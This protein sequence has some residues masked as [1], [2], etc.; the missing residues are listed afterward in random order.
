MLDDQYELLH[1]LGKGGS[2]Q[3][4]SAVDSEGN[5][6][7]IKVIRND[8]DY[9]QAKAEH[10]IL[11]EN[12]VMEKLGCHNNILKSIACSTDGDI[13]YN[14]QSAKVMYHVLEYCANGTLKDYVKHTG[15]FDENIAKFSFIQ[16]VSAVQHLHQNMFVHMDLKLENILLDDYFNIRLA[17]LGTTY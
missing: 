13:N 7:A 3:V 17:D 14:G 8:K 12:F 1:L 2:S 11:R 16:I 10:F 5:K 4:F 9:S 15:A 6:F